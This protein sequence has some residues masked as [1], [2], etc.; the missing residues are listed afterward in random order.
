MQS[1]S[2]YFKT[3]PI[4]TWLFHFKLFWVPKTVHTYTLR[5]VKVYL[6]Y[7]LLL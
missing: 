5:S 2:V 4:S 6:F 1:P 3:H 7:Y